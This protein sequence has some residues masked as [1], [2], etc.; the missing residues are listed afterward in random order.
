MTDQAL[1]K[2]GRGRPP[3]Y[4]GQGKRQNFTFRITPALRQR[5]IA[6]VQVSGRSLSE[7]IEFRLYQALSDDFDER[8]DEARQMYADARR[9]V[10]EANAIVDT[11]RVQA[12]R[13]AG[14]QLLRDIE[15]RPT[16]V[17]VD[18]TILDA[19][20]DGILCS[21]FTTRDAPGRTESR[22]MTA[23]EGER[24]ANEIKQLRARLEA[25]L[26]VAKKSDDAA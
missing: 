24:L 13:L 26:V 20:A 22:P 21:G 4:A 6:T 1:P 11:N 17:I 2:R 9:A 7:E 16:R 15:G 14:F 3:K 18:A 10:S 25:A 19:E 8:R 23:E 12:L 5:L